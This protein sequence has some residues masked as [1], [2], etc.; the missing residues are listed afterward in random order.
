MGSSAQAGCGQARCAHEPNRG[1]VAIVSATQANACGV[2]HAARRHCCRRTGATPGFA[3]EPRKPAKYGRAPR[4]ILA[5]TITTRT[6][7]NQTRC[8]LLVALFSCS[9]APNAPSASRPPSTEVKVWGN[10]REMMREGRTESRVAVAPLLV[11][12]HM[13]AVGAIAGMRGE[14]TVVDGTAWLALGERDS[15]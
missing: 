8:I 9:R 3:G 2:G 11:P 13:H 15:G 1:A 12:P 4:P 14:I 6:T 10:L 7:M 5:V